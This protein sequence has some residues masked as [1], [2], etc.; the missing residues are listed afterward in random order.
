[1]IASFKTEGAEDI[2]N[3][4]NTKAARK[5]C[6]ESLWKIAARKFDQLDS[7]T[8]LDELRIPPGNRLELLAGDRTGQ[9][10][11]RINERYRICFT[12][13]QSGPEQVE[14]VDYH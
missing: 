11:I 2:F 6:P 1:M 14:I 13:S 4:K 7:V 10:S 12:W 3:G 5:S 8:T 9:H